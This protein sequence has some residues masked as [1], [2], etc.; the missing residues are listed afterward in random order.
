MVTLLISFLFLL[1]SQRT[2]AQV[3]MNPIQVFTVVDSRSKCSD[4]IQIDGSTNVNQFYFTHELSDK[5][6]LDVSPDTKSNILELKIPA[7][8]FKSSNHRMTE[9]FL[10]LIKADKYPYIQITIH[11]TNDQLMSLVNDVFYPEIDVQLAGK[12]HTY[13]IPGKLHRCPDQSIH[14]SG[15]VHLSLEDF[16]LEPPSKFLGLVKVKNEVFINFG[17]TLSN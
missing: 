12:S 9:D 2:V 7:K 10:E 11:L 17:L 8:N 15:E 5:K 14:V 13:R 1:F 3:S 6:K 16:D 4:Y